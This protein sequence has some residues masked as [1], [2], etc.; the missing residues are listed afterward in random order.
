MFGIVKNLTRKAGIIVLA[1]ALMITT[2]ISADF[3]ENV[4]A[5]ENLQVRAPRVVDGDCEWDCVSFGHYYMNND[6]VK[7]SIKWRV[8]SV[9][10]NNEALLI[11]DQNLEC[12]RFNNEYK[13]ATWENSS[14]REWLN[15][16]FYDAAFSDDEKNAI[17]ST[18]VNNEH[19][20][21]KNNTL[22]E[23]VSESP[24]SEGETDNVYV[25]SYTE[26]L[27]EA[28]GFVNNV[29]QTKYRASVNTQR[30]IN[31]KATS[32]TN[33]NVPNCGIWWL[34]TD[35]ENLSSG[36][37]ARVD[38]DGRI[39][40]KRVAD[41][42][43]CVRPVI[44]VDLTDENVHYVGVVNAEDEMVNYCGEHVRWNFDYRKKTLH[45][46]GTGAMFD[47]SSQESPWYEYRDYIEHVEIGE[48]ITYIGAYALED[49]LNIPYAYLPDSITSIHD[50]AFHDDHQLLVSVTDK[51]VYH[52][53]D[54]E[55]TEVRSTKPLPLDPAS[56]DL[57]YDLTTHSATLT[58]TEDGDHIDGEKYKVY[59]DGRWTGV[60]YDTPTE[61]SIE[62]LSEED[63]KIRVTT[64]FLGRES[65]GR[66]ARTQYYDAKDKQLVDV[67]NPS[68]DED[69]QLIEWD[70]VYFG[71]Y[72]Q[73]QDALKEWYVTA[74][75]KWRVL[76][77]DK[78]SGTALLLAERNLDC[79]P[80][81]TERKYT[82]W[83]T[84]YLRQW[85]KDSFYKTAFNEDEKP[86]V[87]D[88]VL[89]NSNSDKNP[90]PNSK[91]CESTTDKVFVPS[92]DDVTNEDYG[93]PTSCYEATRSRVAKNTDYNVY[94]E[95][96][97]LETGNGVNQRE[98]ANWWL[99]TAG[100][101]NIY[102]LRV[103]Y[104][105]T[106][107]QGREV[108]KKYI[109]VRPMIRVNL[110]CPDL[111]EAGKVYSN[112]VETP[113]PNRYTVKIDKQ[114]MAVVKGGYKFKFPNE[115]GVKG[116]Y[117]NTNTGFVYKPGSEIEVNR[118]M[119]L[120]SI[121]TISVRHGDLTGDVACVNMNVDL[122]GLAFK[123]KVNI[124]GGGLIYSDAFTYGMLVTAEDYY[125]TT[126]NKKLT[127]DEYNRHNN[128]VFNTGLNG[129][130]VL[131]EDEGEYMG[132]IV[133]LHDDITTKFV[134]RGYLK[135]NYNDGT[136]EY[137]YSQDN[138]RGVC[139]KTIAQKLLDDTSYFNELE[140]HQKEAVR[141]FA[142]WED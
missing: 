122:P 34:R 75:I 118:N 84:S 33:A 37:V 14:L 89:D 99:R 17:V 127:F 116:Y 26:A 57:T 78:T 112:G 2:S 129:Y 69:K 109:G 3:L 48:G 10:D 110:K 44:N 5:N 142:N 51:N 131:D 79:V 111:W 39:L 41:T 28:Y 19:I 62:N 123:A 81:Q 15:D 42:N 22:T 119:D 87:L 125:N 92:L 64:V 126:L 94:Y 68:V 61:V 124:N 113:G 27:N 90:W 6:N 30:V 72:L 54:A 1:L 107:N 88:T 95:G 50:D 67:E 9:N 16:D 98:T 86:Y 20:K 141:V 137:I 11:A 21:I 58:W 91:G 38:F 136:S 85:L 76:K 115:E 104:D 63:H 100:K 96:I 12:I 18:A 83:K 49:C 140:D 59:V 97:H 36:S 103:D 47:F 8:L 105:G 55:E 139:I 106:A 40:A 23:E 52:G 56:V 74:P 128:K 93:F 133:G 4:K 130:N 32:N 13:R 138:V 121:R 135:I 65:V 73:N 46:E 60:Y 108:D 45:I 132:G 70:C 102:N 7:E 114:R 82:D 71:R 29:Y 35:V 134:A 53:E 120:T 24:M 66:A 117:D 77:V 25:L 31:Q 101:D 43:A 80:Y